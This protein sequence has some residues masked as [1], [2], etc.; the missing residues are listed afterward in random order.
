MHSVSWALD[1]RFLLKL[2]FATW[3]HDESCPEEGLCCSY[4]HS[5]IIPLCMNIHRLAHQWWITARSQLSGEKV[6]VVS[7]RQEH[8]WWKQPAADVPWPLHNF[9]ARLE[10]KPTALQQ[11]MGGTRAP[12]RRWGGAPVCTQEQGTGTPAQCNTRFRNLW[13]SKA[14]VCSISPN[15]LCSNLFKCDHCLCTEFSTSLY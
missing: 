4:E 2:P 9:L 6:L 15:Y 5:N 11:G 1:R 13:F 3:N 8:L 12:H 7:M 10:L 14:R